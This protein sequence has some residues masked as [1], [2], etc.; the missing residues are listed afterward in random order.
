[1]TVD[2]KNVYPD[3][4]RENNRW[5]APRTTSGAATPQGSTGQ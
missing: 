2:P 5:D 3:V 1:V 4:R